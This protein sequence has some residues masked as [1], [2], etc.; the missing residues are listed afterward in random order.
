MQR[1]LEVLERHRLSDDQ[2]GFTLT[3]VLIVV[4]ILGILASIV[5]FAVQELD[6]TSAQASCKAD[7]KTVE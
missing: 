3:E 7:Y 1:A 2:D 4:V 5:I 6:G